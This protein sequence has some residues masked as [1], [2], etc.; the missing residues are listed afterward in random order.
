MTNFLIIT[1]TFSILPNFFLTFYFVMSNIAYG[2]WHSEQARINKGTEAV[3][4]TG[5]LD[6][7]TNSPIIN[8]HVSCKNLKKLDVGSESD[9]LVV[10][11][12]PVNG[13]YVEVARTEVV[14]NDSNP[15]FVKFFQ[16]LY[17]FET[18]Q[19]LR[20]N[21]YDC[22]SEQAPLEKHD[23]IG[24][25][26]TDVQRLVFNQSRSVEFPITHSSGQS[27][28]VLSLTIEQAQAGA[29][30]M[31]GQFG[32]QKLKK[33]KTFGKNCPY[34]QISKPS[35]SGKNLPIFRSEVVEKAFTCRFK[36]FEIPVQTLCNG[37]MQMP[38]LITVMDYSKKKADKEIGSFTK[39]AMDLLE[40]INQP[41]ELLGKNKKKVGTVTFYSLNVEKKPTFYDYLQSGLQLNLITAIDFTASNGDPSIP[42]SLHYLCE[43]HLNQYE[44]CIWE[45]GNVVCPYDT[46]Q[47]FP[48]YGFGGRVNE[49]VSHCF[50]LTFNPENPNVS[51]LQEIVRVYKQSLNTVRLSGP[52]LFEP[53]IKAATAVA[54]QSFQTSHTYTILMILTDGVINDMSET[55]NAIVAASDAPL[56]I[57]VVGVGHADFTAMNMLDSDTEPLI[58]S[59]GLRAK[60]DIVQFVPFSKF[61]DRKGYGLSAEV[62]AEIPNQVSQYCTSHGFF[63]Q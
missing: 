10:L 32:V 20:F 24:T 1:N 38:L 63:P 33:V 36:P 2:Q 46:D 42:S 5:L 56:S 8:I 28:G 3:N 50:P 39:N 11:F 14:W 62:L 13:Q 61:E 59:R 22:D 48:V 12:V 43:D 21:I 37:D 6:T 60:R 53:I 27:R 7:P 26:D 23:F 9:P 57:I 44:T 16:A 54:Q 29:D 30:V 52:T 25:V 15:T 58:S 49:T 45:V 47:Q 34:I 19:P 17:I 41:I 35:E 40:S 51:G 4:N 55:I 31:K 18:N